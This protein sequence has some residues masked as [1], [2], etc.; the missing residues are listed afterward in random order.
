MHRVQGVR[1]RRRHRD[2]CYLGNDGLLPFIDALQRTTRLCRLK[3]YGNDFTQLT[4]ARLL[5]AVRATASLIHLKAAAA[6]GDPIPEL[7]EAEA[8]VT[9]RE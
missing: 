1:R 4:A 6:G 8:V 9:A 7:V 3:C 5:A 2:V